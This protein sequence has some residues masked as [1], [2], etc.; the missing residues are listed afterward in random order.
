MCSSVRLRMQN[1]L[2]EPP[3]ATLTF[4]AAQ[5]TH[6]SLTAINLLIPEG[7]TAW[8]DV[9]APGIEPGLS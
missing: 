8:L 4:A 5:V 7:W 1:P 2:R 9:P 6:C 3:D